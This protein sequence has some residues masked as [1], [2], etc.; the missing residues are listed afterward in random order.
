M[1]EIDGELQVVISCV[2]IMELFLKCAEPI[3]VR[4][5]VDE[6]DT[7]VKMDDNRRN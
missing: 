4:F 1:D 6:D 5:F 2:R 3:R 7:K